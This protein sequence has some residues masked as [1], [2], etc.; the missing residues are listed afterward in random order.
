MDTK[1]YPNTENATPISVADYIVEPNNI[2]V[3]IPKNMYFGV[4]T[5]FPANTLLQNNIT[6]FDWVERNKLQPNFWGRNIFGANCITKEEIEFLRNRGC[7]VALIYEPINSKETEEDGILSAQEIFDHIFKLGMRKDIAVFLEI[8]D[9][10]TVT[11]SY[12]LGFAKELLN[13][14]LTPGFKANTDAQFMFDRKFSR[15]LNNYRDVFEKCIVWATAPNL[16]EYYRTT[17]SHLV[18]PDV[19]IPFAPS[20]INKNDICIWQYGKE[21]HPIYDDINREI[22]FNVNL[23]KETNTIFKHMI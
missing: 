5:T 12:M 1:N 21:C 9:V 7:R 11:N 18:H 22:T 4:D 16:D 15:C 13:L 3:I 17:N 23:T 6:L 14:N 20:G 10:E 8:Q 19:W 2:G